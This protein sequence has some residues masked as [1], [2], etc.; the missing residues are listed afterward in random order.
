MSS[1]YIRFNVKYLDGEWREETVRTGSLFE[2]RRYAKELVEMFRHFLLKGN[3][4]AYTVSVVTTTINGDKIEVIGT[5][6]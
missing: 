3:I 2:N 1:S 4:L 5:E 6:V